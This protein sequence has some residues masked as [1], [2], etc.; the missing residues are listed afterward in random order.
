MQTI[1]VRDEETRFDAVCDE[2]LTAQSSLYAPR[3]DPRVAG[4]LRLSVDVGFRTCRRGHR[5]RVR[6]VR[7]MVPA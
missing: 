7:A 2:C 4:T 3:G 6:R 1:Y 5:I